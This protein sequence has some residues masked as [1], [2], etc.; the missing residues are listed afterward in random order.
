MTLISTISS[1]EFSEGSE[2]EQLMAFAVGSPQT[3]FI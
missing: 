2:S 3:S 1:G